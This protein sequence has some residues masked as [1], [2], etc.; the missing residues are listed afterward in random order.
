MKLETINPGKD[1]F[2]L[3]FQVEKGNFGI[4]LEQVLEVIIPPR[5]IRIPGDP[6]MAEGIIGYRGDAFTVI[7]IQSP[8]E[9]Q[10][11]SKPKGPPSPD[12]KYEL[13]EKIILLNPAPVLGGTMRIALQADRV[14][15]V[16]RREEG[17]A[18]AVP[19]AAGGVVTQASIFEKS[20]EF[21]DVRGGSIAADLLNLARFRRKIVSSFG[22][23]V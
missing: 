17:K 3:L 19:E 1:G 16:F 21:K 7:R 8:A 11:G 18:G 12:G 20:L 5:L 14:R 9:N 22:S 23:L 4:P 13:E 15:G 6:D 10:S 2:L